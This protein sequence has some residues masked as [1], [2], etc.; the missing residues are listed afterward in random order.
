MRYNIPVEN[1]EELRKA[2]T[3]IQKKAIKHG[4][5]VVFEEVDEFFKTETDEDGN[6]ITRKYIVVEA[7]GEAKAECWV[8]AGVSSQFSATRQ[9]S[10]SLVYDCLQNAVSFECFCVVLESSVLETFMDWVCNSSAF[11]NKQLS[12]ISTNNLSPRSFII[13]AANLYNYRYKIFIFFY[14]PFFQLAIFEAFIC[15]L[16]SQSLY[17]IQCSFL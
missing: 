7:E 16:F 6:E 13:F 1:I 11:S 10:L 15:P 14:I 3:R 2:A 4:C 12:S 17:F 8:F 9:G 5:K